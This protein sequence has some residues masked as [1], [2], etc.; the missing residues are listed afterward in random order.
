M[1]GLSL[2][3]NHKVSDEDWQKTTKIVYAHSDGT[4]VPELFRSYT[5][6][7]TATEVVV[8]ICDYDKRLL[9]KCYS[10]SAKNFKA[11]ISQL[12]QMGVAKGKEKDFPTGGSSESLS[13]YKGDQ[14]Y[15][16]AYDSYGSGTLRLSRGSLEA[17]MKKL[18]PSIDDMVERTRAA[19][20]QNRLN[21]DAE[22]EN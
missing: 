14:N 13:L 9:A 21:S 15:F 16:S 20:R 17:V 6:T 19:E 18:V 22:T 7:V 3:G 11:V 4:I 2:F 1:L 5:I 10:N 8:E 12:Q